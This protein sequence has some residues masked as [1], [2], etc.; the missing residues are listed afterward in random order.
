MTVALFH[1]IEAIEKAI[2]SMEA[3]IARKS[4]KNLPSRGRVNPN[5]SIHTTMII[6]PRDDI[7]LETTHDAKATMDIR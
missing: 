7:Y 5:V 2:A 3:V 6:W 1:P 4:T